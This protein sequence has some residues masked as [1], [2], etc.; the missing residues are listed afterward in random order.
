MT[1]LL[2]ENKYVIRTNDHI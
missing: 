1:V 2:M